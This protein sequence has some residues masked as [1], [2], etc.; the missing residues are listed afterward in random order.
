MARDASRRS[1]SDQEVDLM[2]TLVEL[3]RASRTYGEG[4]SAVHALR[5]VTLRID[6]GEFVA[7]VGPSGSGKS[8]LLHVVG[9]VDTATAGTLRLEERDVTRLAERE[10]AGIR[11]RRI[12]FVFQQFFLLPILTARENVELPLKEAGVPKAQRRA[13]ADEL[14]ARVGLSARASHF[15]SALSGGEQQRVAIARALANSPS[16]VLADE[17]TGELDSAT[18]AR[19]MD[20]LDEVNRMG[21]AVVIV[22]HDAA[23][24]A[25][26]RRTIHMRD[27]AIERIVVRGTRRA[28]G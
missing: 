7:I 19:V 13:R 4:A 22:T 9:L 16:L 6:P 21:T 17:P 11:L 14:L 23:V 10:R 18:G 25:R 26:A 20:L 28:E 27:G 8:T 1:R 3:D 24:A 5:E 2:A 12:G 15:P